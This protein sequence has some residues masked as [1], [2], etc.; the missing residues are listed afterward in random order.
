[1][2]NFRLNTPYGLDI[3][4]THPHNAFDPFY[5]LVI[6]APATSGQ[7]PSQFF[8][9]LFDFLHPPTLDINLD[10]LVIT[11]DFNYSYHHPHMSSQTSL[12]WVSFLDDQFYNALQKDDL[13]ELP[14]FRL[15]DN[16]FSTA[17]YTFV[18]QP[19]CSKVIEKDII[20]KLSSGWSAAKSW[21]HIKCQ[22]KKIT[23]AFAVDYTNRRTKTIRKLQSNRNKFLRSKPPL[24]IR[25][26]QLPILV[27]QIASLQQELTDIMALKA[28]VRWQEAGE[29]S[30]KYLKSIYR[31]RTVEQHITT[32]RSDDNEDPVEGTDQLLPI[33]QQFYQS[34]YDAVP[35][36]DL[37]LDSYLQG[38]SDLPQVT[39]AHC[40]VLMAPITID[41]I[42]QETAR[43]QNKISGPGED[44]LGYAFLYQ[45]LRYP[46][47]Q[48]LVLKVYNQAH[49]S[50]IFPHSWQGLRSSQLTIAAGN[51]I[52]YQPMSNWVYVESL[53]RGKWSR[54]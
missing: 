53:Y 32:L 34:L 24:A 35:V 12:Q 30:I 26:H 8:D 47:L 14:T 33:T 52:S 40:D 7:H 46:P 29:T 20:P 31:K 51:T 11:G 3:V 9:Q 6:Y 28:N 13:H 5:V 37:Q 43:V 54:A 19:W 16:M 39:S 10:R 41:E 2:P 15:N 17:D 21:D 49:N 4:V 50:S 22:V 27:Q 1:M 25:L 18:S 42:I 44:G 36:D 23:C 45:L 48:E 38:I